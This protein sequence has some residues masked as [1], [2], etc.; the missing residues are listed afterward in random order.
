MLLLLLCACY[1]CSQSL[2]FIN[3]FLAS[4]QPA[5]FLLLLALPL[6]LL[7]SSYANVT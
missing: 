7:L 2:L 6:L 3:K 4:S 1:T 5:S